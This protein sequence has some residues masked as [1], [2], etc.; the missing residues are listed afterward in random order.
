M[1]DLKM[2]AEQSERRVAATFGRREKGDGT[3]WES[4]LAAFL[5]N[6]YRKEE[7]LDLFARFRT[8]EG[9]MDSL[10]RRALRCAVL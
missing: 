10:M 4:D 9:A 2:E 7:L 3:P 5:R 6:S 8:G 1:S